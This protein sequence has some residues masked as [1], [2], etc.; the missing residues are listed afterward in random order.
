MTAFPAGFPDRS[1]TPNNASSSS[2]IFSIS[3][4]I[5]KKILSGIKKGWEY[6]DSVTNLVSSSICTF[7]E[8]SKSASKKTVHILKKTSHHIEMLSVVDIP[9]NISKIPARIKK[10]WK[11]FH[12]KDHEGTVLAALSFSLFMGNL[13]DSLTTLVNKILNT[14]AVKQLGWISAIS[15]PLA[16]TLIATDLLLDCRRLYKLVKFRH[17]FKHHVIKKTNHMQCSFQELDKILTPFLDK[18]MGHE[19]NN[20]S[21]LL[22]RIL[23]RKTSGKVVFQFKKLAEIMKD[24]SIPFDAKR[25]EIFMRLKAIEK[26]Q[27]NE[28]QFKSISILSTLVTSF[29]IGIILEPPAAIV[30]CSLLTTSAIVGLGVQ[31]YRDW[32][33]I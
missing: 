2:K 13:F 33:N 10:I 11:N 3:N 4:Q 8:S 31:I 15:L 24:N 32:K 14:L 26:L 29:A 17:E 16:I 27:K 25:G 9:I 28:V 7:I 23:K 12:F 6:K 20:K 1:L 5:E 18:H 22:A 21:T 30:S 19:V